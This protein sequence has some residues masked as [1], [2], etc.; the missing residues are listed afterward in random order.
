MAVCFTWGPHSGP[1]TF[2]CSIFT[3]FSLLCLLAT[4]I[5]DSFFL[6]WLPIIP[7]SS[8]GGPNS[9][10][11]GALRSLWLLPAE[12]G[13][14]GVLGLHPPLA[15]LKP[16]SPY[17]SVHLRMSDIFRGQV[18]LYILVELALHDVACWPGQRHTWSNHMV[19]T[20]IRRAISQLQISPLQEKNPP[21]KV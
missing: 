19:I 5:L 4:T 1:W 8:Q 15:R 6:F 18:V 16:Q 7:H 10:G 17:S 2:L 3:G 12:V 11:I 14:Q 21:K 13:W 20:G 9:L